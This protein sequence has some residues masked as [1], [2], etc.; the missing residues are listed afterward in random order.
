MAFRRVHDYDPA[1]NLTSGVISLVHS[2]KRSKSDGAEQ[3]RKLLEQRQYWSR[4]DIEQ[5]QIMALALELA[6]RSTVYE[7]RKRISDEYVKD[8]TASALPG[9][10][11]T[12]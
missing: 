9:C 8:L 4:S 7:V 12:R 10:D 11:V 1:D 5:R 6:P 3:V 2:R